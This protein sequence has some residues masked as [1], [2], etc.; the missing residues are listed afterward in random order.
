VFHG[1]I[2]GTL[3]GLVAVAAGAL[4]AAAGARVADDGDP[5]R[6]LGSLANGAE[7]LRT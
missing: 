1:P 5:R 4:V 3:G 2:S 7:L 6:R